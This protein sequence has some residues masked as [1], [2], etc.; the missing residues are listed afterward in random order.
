[1]D[2]AVA[3]WHLNGRAGVDTQHPKI[4]HNCIAED[5]RQEVNLQQWVPHAQQWEM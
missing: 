4:Q 3:T 1:M 5:A 2:I